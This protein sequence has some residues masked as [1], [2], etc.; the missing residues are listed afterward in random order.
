MQDKSKNENV[1]LTDSERKE[2]KKQIAKRQKMINNIKIF[3]KLDKLEHQSL[4][5]EFEKIYKKNISLDLKN[6]N[7]QQDDETEP[8]NN[9][10]E[11]LIKKID[12]VQKIKFEKFELDK[13]FY[14]D[15]ELE[16]Y[17]KL[18]KKSA[19]DYFDLDKIEIKKGEK[20]DKR[21]KN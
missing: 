8:K 19:A 3:F 18:L 1:L 13:Y 17:I 7:D 20:N 12:E 15:E 16:K 5:K 9:E 21:K 10:I 4:D 11:N 2:L 6:F 14:F